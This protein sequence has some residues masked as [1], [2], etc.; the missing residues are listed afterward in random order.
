MH[1]RV[2][3][4]VLAA[5]ERRVLAALAS[6]MPALVA[7]DHLTALALGAMAAAGLALVAARSSAAGGWLFAACLAVNWFG[8]SLDGTLARFRRIERPRYGYYVDHVIDLI[9][10]TCLLAGFAVSGFMATAV[11]LALLAA[12]LLASAETFLATHA[13]GTFRLSFGGVGPTEL[14]VL[15]AAGVVAARAHV[16]TDVL[17]VHARVFDLAGVAG[18]VGLGAAFLT[19]AVQNGRT[20]YRAEP[21]RPPRLPVRPAD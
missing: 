16:W 14:R 20:L 3:G 19:N 7:P 17:G 9:G 4:G 18:A 10:V 5:P 15:L 6:R 2:N 11:A 1:I 12:Y 13:A 21:C 8:D